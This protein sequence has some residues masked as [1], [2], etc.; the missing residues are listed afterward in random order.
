MYGNIM[1]L[2]GFLRCANTIYLC[3]PT[4]FKSNNYKF[5]QLYYIIRTYMAIKT[6]FV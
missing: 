4:Q 5:E 1:K 2:K 3:M 6:D